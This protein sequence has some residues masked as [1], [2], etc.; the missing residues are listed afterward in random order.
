MIPEGFPP[1]HGLGHLFTASPVDA[2][3]MPDLLACCGRC[4]VTRQCAQIA[5]QAEQSPNSAVTG[6]WGGVYIIAPSARPGPMSDR[7]LA[8]LAQ[9]RAAAE[10]PT[11]QRRAAAEQPTAQRPSAH[12]PSALTR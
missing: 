4:H 10:Q 8:A 2:L 5:L 7:R 9:L 11:A 1:C 6:I 12:Q 3:L